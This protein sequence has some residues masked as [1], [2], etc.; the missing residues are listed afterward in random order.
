MRKELE[1]SEPK[2]IKCGGPVGVND[3]RIVLL[4]AGGHWTIRRSLPSLD[5]TRQKAGRLARS[6][7]LQDGLGWRIEKDAS[8]Q[9]TDSLDASPL[10]SM[11]LG[12]VKK[13]VEGKPP[14]CIH[15][16]ETGPCMASTQPA[17]YVESYGR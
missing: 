2:P 11:A 16:L 9:W 7:S 5:I 14:N 1:R 4:A 15:A 8:R 3:Q 12:L 17:V 6:Y 10:G 13:T